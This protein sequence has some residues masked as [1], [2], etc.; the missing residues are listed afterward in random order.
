MA[1]IDYTFEQ[2]NILFENSRDAVFYME[3]IE[4]DYKYIY[5]NNAALKL[6]EKNPIGKTVC[7]STPPHLS[8]NILHYYN[9][10]FEK[11]E[12]VDFED[13]TYTKSEIR[14]QNTSA[15]PITRGDKQFV[16]ATTK[17]VPFN[18]D[19]E[20]KYLFMRSVFFKSFL[21]TVLIST[22]LQLLEANPKFVED[23]N[24]QLDEVHKKNFFDLPFIDEKSAPL[25]KKYLKQAQNGANITSKMLYFIDKDKVRRC[26]TATFSSLTSNDKVIA[27]FVI[28]QEITQFIKQGE[29][30]KT[31]SHGF[32][33]F[34]EAINSAADVIFADT[35]GRIVDV[36]DR[37]IQ[38]TGYTREEL[39]GKPHS[40][41]NSGIHSDDYFKDLWTTVNTG[42]VWRNE[43]CNRKKNGDTYWVDSTIIP[44]LNEF[45]QI[46]QFLTIQFNISAKKKLMSEL[47][48]VEQTFRAITENTND[49]IVVT[50]QAGKIKY[51][52]PSYIRKL[53]YL[54]NELIGKPYEQLLGEESLKKWRN[55]I[56]QTYPNNNVENKMELL[57][58]SKK[59]E[60][61]W[62]EGNYTITIDFSQNEISE[63]IMVSRE[64]TERKELENKLRFMAYHDSLTQLPNRRLL[65]KEF[66]PI[67]EKANANFN[68]V[69]FFYIDG[70][71]FKQ[72]NDDF[73]HDIGDEFLREFGQALVRSVKSEDLVVR[74]GGDEF[75]IVVTELSRNENIRI[76]ELEKYINNIRETLK[77]GFEVRNHKFSPTSSIGI[78]WYPEHGDSLDELVDL[79][80]RALYKAKQV[81]KNNYEICDIISN[82]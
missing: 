66:F 72:V 45:G 22:D 68:S 41:F 48:Q 25:L 34:K 74:L 53:G 30:L 17:E 6:I 31:T 35:E 26:F 80:D 18:R 54:E 67:L 56:S 3:K 7:Q 32:E 51:A 77:I 23:F 15:V 5:L 47:Y 57:L 12:Q 39:F 50:D 4:D 28:L 82:A 16:L 64:I 37:V 78:S 76:R 43:V 19:M 40:I 58:Q 65:N 75:L 36:N 38:N 81:R 11:H 20:D 49:F 59:S 14:K 73:G 71:N 24:I 79:A 62:T 10:S 52:S 61:I 13:F 55:I 42:G 29:E 33:T 69:A 2:L 60:K 21:S 70:D 46:H 63:I 1:S 27:V 9:L 44:M 8:K